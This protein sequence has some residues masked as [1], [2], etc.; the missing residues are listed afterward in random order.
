MHLV[1]RYG[2]N[3]TMAPGAELFALP[4]SRLLW[5]GASQGWCP[6]TVA[7]THAGV[8]VWRGIRLNTIGSG[9]SFEVRLP[10]LLGASKQ[11]NRTYAVHIGPAAVLRFVTSPDDSNLQNVYFYR[12]PVVEVTDL[13]GNRVISTMHVVALSLARGNGM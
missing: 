9:V 13:G 8:A 11:T 4:Q 7:E 1:L 12:Q 6:P 5:C 3:A 2:P 10:S